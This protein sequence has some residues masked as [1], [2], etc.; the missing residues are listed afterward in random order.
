MGTLNKHFNGHSLVTIANPKI[1]R[2]DQASTQ[3][4]AKLWAQAMKIRDDMYFEGE[5]SRILI[6][7]VDGAAAG[8]TDQQVRVNVVDMNKRLP[9]TTFVDAVKADM[10]GQLKG[11][12]PGNK[13]R[14]L[15]FTF[16]QHAQCF[17]EA[18]EDAIVPNH[19]VITSTGQAGFTGCWREQDE[20]EMWALQSQ[21]R[22][23]LSAATSAQGFS[24]FM[25][26]GLISGVSVVDREIHILPHAAPNATRHNLNDIIKHA[27]YGFAYCDQDRKIAFMNNHPTIA[28]VYKALRF[29]MNPA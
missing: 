10:Y 16:G 8:Q 9:G 6:S 24:I 25:D 20:Q 17:R 11:F 3:A 23:V 21:I 4:E 26:C 5:S 28:K 1:T 14:E 12:I 22:G 7:A 13:E 15:M 27:Y 19:M 2:L 18:A 29:G